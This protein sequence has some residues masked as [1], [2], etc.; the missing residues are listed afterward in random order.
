MDWQCSNEIKHDIHSRQ[1]LHREKD[2]F[3]NGGVVKRLKECTLALTL[4]IDGEKLLYGVICLRAWEKITFLVVQLK[5][6][7]LASLLVSPMLG[8]RH[9]LVQLSNNFTFFSSGMHIFKHSYLCTLASRGTLLVFL[10]LTFKYKRCPA[11]TSSIC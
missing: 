10:A 6:I 1:K 5:F 3:K 7:I 9:S 8:C 2:N 11:G 4:R